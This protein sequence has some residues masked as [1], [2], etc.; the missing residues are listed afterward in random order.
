MPK[1]R[2]A[3]ATR[4]AL[5]ADDAGRARDA[6]YALSA[7]GISCDSVELEEAV[8]TATGAV[9]FAPA[10]IPSPERAAAIAPLCA[11]LASESR[12]MVALC[13]ATGG[14]AKAAVQRAASLAYMRAHG[15]IVCT[16]PD[17]WLE[18]L[19]LLSCFGCPAGPRTA[20]VAPPD[21]W[22]AAS[23]SALSLDAAARGAR[24]STVYFEASKVGATDVVLVD[25]SELP[26]HPLPRARG[27]LVV[28]VVGRAEF[29]SDDRGPALVGLRP[30][31]AAAAAVGRFS[32]RLTEGL[33]PARHVAIEPDREILDRRLARI[34]RV[35]G[36][37]ETKL[38]LA[39]F[40]V[41]VTRQAVATTPS[42]A[43]RKAKEVGWP[44]EIKPWGPDVPSEREGCP[45]E[46]RVTSAAHVRRAFAA[47][48]RQLGAPSGSPVIVRETPPA[49]RELSAS[50]VRVGAVGLTVIVDVPGTPGPIAA[51]APLREADAL[52][53]TRRVEATRAGDLEPDREALARLL[54]NASAL[55]HDCADIAA[56][57]MPRIVVGSGTDTAIVVDARCERTE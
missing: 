56:L 6:T 26:R 39:A 53:L 52:E 21:S 14:S 8:D 46:R 3:V 20:I 43:T 11:E 18:A 37:H 47:V 24:F 13:P 4:I 33:G 22:L 30:A 51:P 5:A 35:G 7:R 50:V 19:V 49:G 57:E 10:Q 48:S 44:V 36:D 12:P 1:L 23:A 9:G 34:G 17:E 16:D 41:P 27:A 29:L 28:P 42:A 32:Q 55:V 45:V 54:I 31:L 40:E 2:K 25:R 38:L 15:A